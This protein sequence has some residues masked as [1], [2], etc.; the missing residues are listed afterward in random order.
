MAG[1]SDAALYERLGLTPGYMLQITDRTNQAHQRLQDR[2][3]RGE[4]PNAT[5]KPFRVV[6]NKPPIEYEGAD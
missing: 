6:V 5:L 2:R 4:V 1:L 3:R